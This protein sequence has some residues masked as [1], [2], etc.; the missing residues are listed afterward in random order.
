MGLFRRR[1]GRKRGGFGKFFKG[2]GKGFQK[3]GKGI[4]RGAQEVG[5]VADK[6]GKTLSKVGFGG[7]LPPPPQELIKQREKAGIKK[8][9]FGQEVG[10]G[11]LKAMGDQGKRYLAP[12]RLVKEIDPLKNTGIGKAG[13]S[14]ISLAADIALAPVSSVGTVLETFGDDKVRGKLMKGDADVITDLAFAPLAFTPVP[15]GV[16]KAATK[17]LKRVGKALVP[18]VAR[19][20]GKE[21][22]K[23]AGRASKTI[24]KTIGM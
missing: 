24:A 17:G 19:G 22:V 6:A 20:I 10:R 5:K 2:V 4:K 1:R 12:T 3:I 14:P 11:F 18:K 13:F 15:S 16:S 9:S 23:Q 8:G 7:T 21:T